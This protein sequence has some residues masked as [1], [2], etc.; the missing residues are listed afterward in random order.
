MELITKSC[1]CGCGRTFR[2]MPNSETE[3]AASSHK[4]QGYL[5]DYVPAPKGSGVKGRPRNDEPIRTM[6]DEDDTLELY[7]DDTI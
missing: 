7:E 1:K 5:A 4:P 6:D 2:V 3:Y